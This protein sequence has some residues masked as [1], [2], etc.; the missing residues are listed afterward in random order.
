MSDEM[1][2]RMIRC[3]WVADSGSYSC[4]V[5]IEGPNRDGL[6]GDVTNVIGDVKLP[7]VAVNARTT[8]DKMAVINI[9]VEISDKTHLDMLVKKLYRIP[10]V[11]EVRRS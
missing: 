3:S 2:S 11:F 10:G 7:L 5:Q 4:D 1:R 8:K 6:L 9:T